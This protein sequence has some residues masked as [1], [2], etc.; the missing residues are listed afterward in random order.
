[1]RDNCAGT[2]LHKAPK[3]AFSFCHLRGPQRFSEHIEKN[4]ERRCIM[5]QDAECVD[6]PKTLQPFFFSESR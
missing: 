5:R 3:G 2:K 4:A 6:P 1:M